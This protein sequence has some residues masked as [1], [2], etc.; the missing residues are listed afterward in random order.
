MNPKG[1]FIVVEGIEGSGKSTLSKRLKVSLEKAGQK[2]L[3]TREPGGTK[4]GQAIRTLLLSDP[5]EGASM[6]FKTELL[7]FFADRAQHIKEVILPA[8][9]V[10]QIV[11]CD[12]Y[13]Y[14]TLA[15]QHYGRGLERGMI[16][17]LIKLVVGTTTPDLV[18][19]VDL[20][21]EIALTRA[22]S[23]S[24]LDRIEKEDI[25]FHTR[26][27]D[28]FLKLAKEDV[29]RFLV[30]DGTLK[31]ENLEELALEKILKGH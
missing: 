8:L 22:K 15:Y 13:F 17:T 1:K 23:R 12:R 28:G 4:I 26:I 24:S 3:L 7:L 14:S 20:D 29:D 10:G 5:Q 25:S 30:L 31:E 9:K 11:L 16:D 19:L 2:V 21:P 18:I 6:D 27:R